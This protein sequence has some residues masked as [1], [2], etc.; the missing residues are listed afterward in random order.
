MSFLSS[1]EI[2]LGKGQSLKI[3]HY[4]GLALAAL[5]LGSLPHAALA[6]KF[7]L[8]GDTSICVPL[9]PSNGA[10]NPGNQQFFRNVLGS[11]TKVAIFDSQLSDYFLAQA[12]SL[13]NFYNSISGV[14]STGFMGTI[15]P[16]SLAGAN[17]F[18]AVVP[19]S[20]FAKSEIAALQTFS[21]G[22]GTIFFLGD[23]NGA[24]PGSNANIN[25]ALTSLGSTLQ[26][27]PDTIDPITYHTISGPNIAANPLTAGITSF[28]YV[29][30]SQV[31]GGT[32]LFFTQTGSAPFVAESGFPA[33]PEASTTASF[34]LLIVL[35]FGGL[36]AAGKRHKSVGSHSVD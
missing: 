22:G 30:T 23:G 8:S 11:G 25:A 31:S 34:G 7:V 15:T 32:N 21:S 9:S 2:G 29:Y 18:V 4:F 14:T 17:L 35:G 24:T 13:N 16:T 1:H 3:S 10:Y 20:A 19:S 28:S 27:V 5:S 6:Q 36:V 26:L 12:T 33:V